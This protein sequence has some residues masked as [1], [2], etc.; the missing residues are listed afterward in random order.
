MAPA[1]S[2]SRGPPRVNDSNTMT[3]GDGTWDFEK[4]NFL[5]PNLQGLNFETMRYNGMANR[6][7]TVAEYHSL[8]MAHAVIGALVFLLFVPAAV[9]F[10]RFYTR[11]PGFAIKY[12]AMLGIFNILLLTVVFVLGWFAVGPNR[13]WTNPHHAIGLAIYVMFLLQA[14]GGRLVRHVQG[15]SIR[16]MF[17]QWSG[18]LIAL[19]GIIQVPLGL[20]LYGSPKYLFILYSLWMAFLFLLYFIFDYRRGEFED[21]DAYTRGGRSELT[22]VPMAW[23]AGGWRSALGFYAAPEVIASRRASTSYVGGGRPSTSYAGAR[24]PSASYIDDDKYTEFDSRR[25]D[26]KKGGG[27]MKAMLG[28]GAALGAGKLVSGMMNRREKK[29]YNDEY[30]AVSTETPRRDRVGRG[31]APA[32]SEYS[33]YTETTRHDAGTASLLP[34]PG[35]PHLAQALSAAEERPQNSRPITTRPTHARTRSGYGIEDSDYSSYVSPSRRRDGDRAAGAGGKGN[36]ILAGLGLGWFAK[37]LADRKNKRQEDY[38]Y[39]DEE[40]TM[41]SRYTGDGYSSPSRTRRHSRRPSGRQAPYSAVG[42]SVTGLTED[43]SQFEPR[44]ADSGHSGPPMPPLPAGAPPIPAPYPASRSR[45]DSQARTDVVEPAVIPAMPAD[46]QGVLH[47]E[48]GSESYFSPGGRPHRRPSERRRAEGQR[49]AAAAA[50]S[51]GALAAEEE[52][53]HRAYT[54]SGPVSVKVKMHDDKDRNVTLRRLTDDEAAASR[55]DQRRRRDNS[56]SSIGTGSPSRQRY[57]R[58]SSQ[59]RVELAAESAVTDAAPLPPLSPPNPAFAKGRKPKDSAYYSGQPAGSASLAPPEASS[60]GSPESHGTWSAM[61]P[62]PGG[63][64]DKPTASAADNRR[65]RRQERRRSESRP[66]GADMFD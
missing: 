53:R 18:R 19:L 9:F 38:R 29:H 57:R 4:N 42:T 48:S 56:V 59:R 36:G 31:T 25:E 3:V 64:G 12:H 46:P 15:R 14:I 45:T 55:R 20:T 34:P 10:A 21:R 65:R 43:S 50:A 39:R 22:H 6:F 47:H 51:A 35:N 33:D 17:H 66:T 13:S 41:V 32:I 23:T 62:S 24:R 44:P 28:V 60:I 2:M 30:S 8:I 37:K 7:S 1:L 11:R 58:D 5:L 27:F 54:P 40:E 49:A 52:A 63:A 61:S 16:V 26:N